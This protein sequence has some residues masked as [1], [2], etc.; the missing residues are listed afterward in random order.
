MLGGFANHADSAFAS[1]Y[2]TIFTNF[3]YTASYLHKYGIIRI[4]GIVKIFRMLGI[5]INY[6]SQK[7]QES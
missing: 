6:Y 3:F 2:F 1:D 4:I 7:S 5:A